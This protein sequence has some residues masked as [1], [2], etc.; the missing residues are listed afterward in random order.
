MFYRH[1]LITCLMYGLV[2]P[3]WAEPGQGDLADTIINPVLEELET[4]ENS[5]QDAEA[6]ADV[7]D[8][9][10]AYQATENAKDI[11]EAETPEISVNDPGNSPEISGIAGSSLIKDVVLVLDNSGSM[12][13]N[14][15]QFLTNNAVTEFINNL[16]ES[17]RAAIVIFDQDVRMAVPLTDISST[18]RQ[19]LL[20]S[21]SQINYKGLYTNSPA[22]IESAIY[23]LKNNG[24]EEARKI[25]VFMT[26]GIVDT[27]NADRD[28]E[29][30]KWLKED[31]AADASDAGIRIFGIAFTENADFELIQS[32]AQKTD[33]EYYRA[34]LA[35]D[36]QNVFSKLNTLINK[37]DEPDIVEKVETRIIEKIVEKVVEPKSEPIIARVPA[38]GTQVP[39]ESE[40]KRS[41][42]ILVALAV[43]IL[44]VIAMVLM[45]LRGNKSKS[46]DEETAQEAYLND[47]HGI[48]KQASFALGNK[49]TMLGRVAGKDT[50]YL[51]YFVIPE[52]TIGRRHSLIEYKDFS[53]W[54]I[55]QGSINGTF[56]NDRAVTSE[57]RLKHGD[58]IRLHKIEFEF[59]IPEMADSG[60]TVISKTVIAGMGVPGDD[61]ATLMPGANQ[62]ATSHDELD[63][64]DLPEP[65]FDFDITGTADSIDSDDDEEDTVMR[66]DIPPAA[67]N[68]DG[69]DETIMLDD[70]SADEDVMEG[71]DD[72]DA[73]IRPD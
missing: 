20:D 36:L 15:P 42:L 16:D 63:E 44:A 24:R 53:Y 72:D 40:R 1:L 6:I 69:S 43:L 4:Q 5:L 67:E 48:T 21:L 32:L 7:L 39:D 66:G 54:I 17:T 55:D 8:P 37:P 30:T 64:I 33:G 27:G 22:A 45:L 35:D 18:S 68:A 26:D 19:G 2:N 62:S 10:T 25:I 71:Y 41:V 23:D 61:E 51:N 11:V 47:I 38:S 34:L 60:M 65:D 3:V 14:D 73:T 58:I 70:D 28:L 31:L 12:K 46:R 13:K 56:V 49:P 9:V 59:V 50:E 29:K 52:T 57:V